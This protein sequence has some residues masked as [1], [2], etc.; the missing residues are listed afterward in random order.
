MFRPVVQAFVAAMFDTGMITRFAAPYDLSLSVIITRGERQDVFDH[1][2]TQWEA[3]LQPHR[4]SD[5]FRSKSM[6]TIE[7][8]PGKAGHALM[9]SQIF[10]AD[11]LSLR[12]RLACCV[13]S[14][15]VL[16]VGS[17]LSESASASPGIARGQ[18]HQKMRY[19][20]VAFGNAFGLVFGV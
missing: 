3:E 14:Q 2:Q 5:H 18:L 4:M 17:H 6:A 10:M 19:N 8:I 16:L 7:R 20:C 1:P 11:T 9:K 15:H 13:S 12:C